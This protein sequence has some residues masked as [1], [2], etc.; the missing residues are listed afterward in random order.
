MALRTHLRAMVSALLLLL[1]TTAFSAEGL[2]EV[3][4]TAQKREQSAQN[5]PIAIVA[6]SGRELE[7]LDL[8]S[9]AD[10]PRVVPGVNVAGSF[11]GQLLTFSIRGVTQYDFS[12]HTEAP[13]A[14][15]V[16]EAY[17]ASQQM[18]S[19]GMFDVEQVE[20]LKGPQGT[21]FGHNATG[22][23]IAIR[24]RKPSDSV[25]GYA[26]VTYGRFDQVK[27]EGAYGGPITDTL[28]ARVSLYSDK[29]GPY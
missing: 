19:F 12:L 18:Q 17:L 27:F 21:L 5:V 20:V 13:I 1:T 11:G 28:S 26:R 9:S 29:Y 14:M 6:V 10:I 7:R 23:A 2:E 16:D 15:Y 24:T 25:D 22:G 8:Q 4:V 3:I